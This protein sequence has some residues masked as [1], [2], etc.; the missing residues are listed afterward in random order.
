MAPRDTLNEYFKL[1]PVVK[2]LPNFIT[3]ALAA[4]PGARLRTMHGALPFTLRYTVAISAISFFAIKRLAF[5]QYPSEEPGAHWAT[6]IPPIARTFIDAITN[7][8]YL[9]EN[10]SERVER[11]VKAGVCKQLVRHQKL[12]ELHGDDPDWAEPLAALKEWIDGTGMCQS[13]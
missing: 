9:M 12:C 1:D 3:D 4:A 13:A 7:I 8:V 2:E 5:P 11:F 6:A 10:P